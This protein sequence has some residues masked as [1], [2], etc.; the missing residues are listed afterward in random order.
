MVWLLLFLDIVDKIMVLIL[1]V[2][3]V[4]IKVFFF[5]I[6]FWVLVLINCICIE[7]FFVVF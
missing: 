4:L 3:R 5:E 6:L 2:M 1:C 7:E